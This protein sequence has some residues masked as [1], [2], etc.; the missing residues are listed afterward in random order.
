MGNGLIKENQ[1]T[2]MT[3]KD[4]LI[5]EIKNVLDQSFEDF[6]NV[7]KRKTWPAKHQRRWYYHDAWFHD[8]FDQPSGQYLELLNKLSRTV[9]SRSLIDLIDNVIKPYAMSLRSY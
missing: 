3:N 2:I 1:M 8:M 9:G 6:L 4:V 5:T 7:T